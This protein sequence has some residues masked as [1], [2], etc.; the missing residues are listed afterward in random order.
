[1]IKR[2]LAR[3]GHAGDADEQ[4]CRNFQI[5]ILEI[6][7]RCTG[8]TQHQLIVGRAALARHRDAALAGKILAGQRALLAED[9]LDLALG[10]DFAAVHAGA[11][12]DVDDVVGAADR[13]FVVLDDD[14]GVAEV[15]QAR[16]RAE[17]AFVVA[18]VQADRRLIEYVHDA[19][20]ARA[21]LAGQ[22]D[23]LCLAARERVG[24]AI[25]RQVIQADVD[26][27]AQ[28]L[29]DF[30]DDL[31][32]DLAA[33]SGQFQLVE[34]VE[35]LVDRQCGQGRQVAV[36]DE[37]VARAAVQAL[38][39]AIRTRALADELGQFLAHHRRFGFL[40]APLEVR[41]DA[42]EAVLAR[43]AAAGFGQVAEADL[44]VAEPNSTACWMPS[45]NCSHGVSMSNL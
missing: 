5:D 34:K 2:R 1:L 18:L 36:A 26:E 30:L 14:D 38:A 25:E 3:T 11:G 40:V 19:D 31:G 44:L 33:P 21:D 24:L 6:V 35:R 39:L 43:D 22:A 37:D 32:R 7:A 15:A 13:V 23:A 12:A 10:D 9:V 29:A 27:E 20:Q 42:L 8:H 17:Q 45:G 41:H 28:A 16:Q 4:T